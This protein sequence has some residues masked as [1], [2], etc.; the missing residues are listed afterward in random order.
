VTARACALGLP[1]LLAVACEAE[2][3][4]ASGTPGG[5]AAAAEAPADPAADHESAS[6]GGETDPFAEEIAMRDAVVTV[7]G[8]EVHHVIGGPDDG[9]PV[10]LLHGGRYHSGTW[11]ELGTLDALAGAGFRVVAV[12]LPGFGTSSEGQAQAT[13][14]LADLVPALGLQ[15]P[16]LLA[17]SMSGAFAF[18]WLVE[19][20]GDAAGLVACAPVEIGTWA[21]RLPPELPALLVWGSEDQGIPPSQ[22]ELLAERLTHTRMLL[23][24]GAG[25]PSYLDA[26]DAFHE[27][28]LAFCAEVHGRS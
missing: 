8:A 25:H 9:A 17:A 19:H 24:E 18:P 5:G 2:P 21:P 28:L 7:Q 13:T 6:H 14:F 10:L 15:R 20:P 27:A 12:D 23:L 3:G 26:P 1:L 16:V 11:V 4:P 22:A